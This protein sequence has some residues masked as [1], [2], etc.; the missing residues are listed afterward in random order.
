MICDNASIAF[1]ATADNGP[2]GR[3]VLTLENNEFCKAIRKGMRC[4]LDDGEVIIS[5]VEK[6]NGHLRLVCESK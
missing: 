3:V 5:S 6:S 1:S 4:R 2:E